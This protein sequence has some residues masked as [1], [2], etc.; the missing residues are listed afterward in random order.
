MAATPA[1]EALN[2]LLEKVVDALGLDAEVT[3]EDDGELVR[4]TL[5]G[6]DLGLFIGRHGQTIDAVQHLA[7]RVVAGR[8]RASAGWSRSTPR[9]TASAAPRRC[10]AR[11]TTPPTRPCAT[12]GRCRSTRWAP[13]SASSSTSTCATAAT[14]RRT[15]RA[16]SRIATSSSRPLRP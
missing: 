3:V 14:S 7:M 2:E 8:P 10:A 6:E 12:A 1:A 9:A 5:D 13:R 4:G 15:P 16:T 11:P